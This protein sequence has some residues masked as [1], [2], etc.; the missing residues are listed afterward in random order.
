MTVS[1]AASLGACGDDENNTDTDSGTKPDSSVMVDCPEEA[2]DQGAGLMGGCCY[3]KEQGANAD[4]VDL[5]LSSLDIETPPVLANSTVQTIVSAAF[6]QETFSWLLTVEGA[7]QDG[8]VT[9][10]TGFADR[11]QND[12]FS[13]ALNN[14]P[15]EDGAA[16]RWNPAEFEGTIANDTVTGR[17]DGEIIL[18]LGGRDD[19]E[20]PNKET[21]LEL[22]LQ[23]IELTKIELSENRSC[24]GS[25]S[26]SGGY[27]VDSGAF[28][29]FVRVAAAAEG[30]IDVLGD[31]SLCNFVGGI[32]SQSNCEE[33]AR[34]EWDNP[35]NSLCDE[36]G[37]V[38]DTGDNDVCDPLVDCN[39]WVMRA[40]FAAM[41]VEVSDSTVEPT[42][43][44]SVSDASVEDAGTNDAS[45]ADG[46][47]DA[48]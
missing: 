46:G 32:Q 10:T 39:A 27:T 44:A 16:D 14:A 42:P 40:N 41:G 28:Q 36:S 33:V 17:Y 20:T 4:R 11:N 13:Y 2:P 25:Y 1:L 26:R 3:R 8:A 47:V 18:P 5:R 48:G 12:T 9:I 38:E 34:T 31:I 22:P 24:V 30:T 7:S 29:T 35:P 43:D 15:T 19:P 6:S 45:T 23:G 21:V 37:C